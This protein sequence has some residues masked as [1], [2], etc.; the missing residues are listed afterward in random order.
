[1]SKFQQRKIEQLEKQLLPYKIA[2]T[3]S[4]VACACLAVALFGGF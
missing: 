1:M 3:V 4:C 2:L